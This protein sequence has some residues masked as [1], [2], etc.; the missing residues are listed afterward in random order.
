MNVEKNLEP[1]S[2]KVDIQG[3]DIWN[4]Y[5]HINI[6][7]NMYKNLKLNFYPFNFFNY[8]IILNKLLILFLCNF[9]I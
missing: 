9:L 5:D 1:K 2:M 4:I 8:F 7:Y 6:D 3:R